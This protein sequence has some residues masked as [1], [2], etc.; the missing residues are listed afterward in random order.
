MTQ[1]RLGVN[2]EFTLQGITVF[3]TGGWVT[4]LHLHFKHRVHI[5][6]DNCVSHWRLGDTVTFTF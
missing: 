6:R 2:I 1:L 3:L 5:T 4:Q